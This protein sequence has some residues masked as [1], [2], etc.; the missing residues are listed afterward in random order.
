MPQRP[1]RSCSGWAFR[2]KLVGTTRARFP[3]GK[4]TVLG[5]ARL[6]L[7][8]ADVLLLDEPTNHLDVNAVEWLEDFLKDIRQDLCRHQPRP[9]FSRPHY[10]PR[11]RDRSR[12]G[13]HLQR[14]LFRVSRSN[15]SSAANSSMREYENQQALINKTQEFIRRNLEGQKTKQ[16]K[17]RR[18]L[19]AR[20]DRIEAVTAKNPAAISA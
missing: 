2:R 4:K 18:T 17:S 14:K 11:D 5:M 6:L 20:M 8:I 13:R 15:A 7:S 16:A 3:A 19:L 1:K 10:Q 12:R 9:L